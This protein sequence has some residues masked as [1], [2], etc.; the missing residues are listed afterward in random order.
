V[1]IRCLQHVSFEGPGAICDWAL[2]RGHE[3]EI[4]EAWRAPM[5]GVESFDALIVMGGPMGV[6]DELEL[7]WL[8]GEKTLIRSAIDTSRMVVGICLGAQLMADVLGARVYRNAHREIG[9]LPVDLTAAATTTGIFRGLPDRPVVFQWHGDTFDLPAGAVR[10]ASSEGCCN[11][12]FLAGRRALALQF[13]FESTGAGPVSLASA[14]VLSG[15]VVAVIGPHPDDFDA[16][17]VTLRRLRDAGAAI[18]AFVCHTAS[19]VEDGFCSP[20]TPAVKQWLREQEQRDSLR[21]FGL[22]DD[23]VTFL[24]LERNAADDGQ[25]FDHEANARMLS[26]AIL[27]VRPDLLVLPHGNDTNSGHRNIHAMVGRMTAKDGFPM[28]AWLIRDPKTVS[29]RIDLYTPFGEDEAAWKAEMLRFHRSQHRRNLNTRGRGFD[30]RI[31]DVNRAIAL[32]APFAEAFE[33]RALQ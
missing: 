25:P 27:P 29:M 20:P 15:L 26:G 24:D 33:V 31:L 18:H 22:P 19:G 4:T 17:A 14:E 11:Q 7:P 32:D 9:W 5:P 6:H 21:F 16:V 12:A 30:D 23:C 3:M 8:H 10:L 1:R 28:T 2:A 13:H